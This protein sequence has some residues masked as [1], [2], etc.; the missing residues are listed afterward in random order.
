MIVVLV[1]VGGCITVDERSEP[2]NKQQLFFICPCDT[3]KD[4]VLRLDGWVGPSSFSN[5]IVEFYKSLRVID[6]N[7]G[8]HIT[9]AIFVVSEL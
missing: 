4:F 2:L 3:E 6:L 1:G 9:I 8:C 7:S 5:F